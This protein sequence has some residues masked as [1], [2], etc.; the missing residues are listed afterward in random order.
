MKL[1]N[2]IKNSKLVTTVYMFL[3]KLASY[4][5]VKKNVIMFESFYGKQYS[6]N[7]RAIYE[8]MSVHNPDYI[9]YWSAHKDYLTIF[10]KY[11]VPHIKRFSIKW[12]FYMARAQYWVSNSRL[13]LWLPKPKHTTYIQT[14]HGTPLKKLAIDVRE[15]HVP[16]T[17]TKKYKEDYIKEAEKWDYLISP[18]HYSTKIFRRAFQFEQIMLECGYPRNDF[19]LNYHE[20]Q[21]ITQIKK[22]LDLPTHKKIILY[23]P[24]WRD[25]QFYD[26]GRYKFSVHLDLLKM[27]E[28]LGD[29][30]VV[31]LR[32]HYLVAE[33]IDI[34]DFDGFVYDFSHREDIRELY[35]VAD[36]LI[37]D[38]S[39]VFF[40]FAILKRPMI[41]FVYDIEEYRDNLRG[42]YFDF[43]KKA[44]GLL[45][46]ST[47]EVIA[48]VKRIDR[49]GFTP[50]KEIEAFYDKFCYL[51]D[52]QA[53]KRVVETLFK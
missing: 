32:T 53:T 50:T 43:E 28:A 52:G 44:P 11:Q 25:N 47:E 26:V 17:N 15:A 9:L 38:Y 23:A 30:Y 29:D 33:N 4:L 48:E 41:F 42:F 10:E 12:L 46:K 27:K 22:K 51:E 21:S 3:F 49:D 40:D 5:P 39:S 8:Y 36:I 13:P 14:W 19:L 2:I 34:A 37:T 1:L 31:V 35:V 20:E 45:T 16:G 6:D 18:N 24:T 7:P